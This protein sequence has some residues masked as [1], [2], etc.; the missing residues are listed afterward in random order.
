MRFRTTHPVL[1]LFC[2]SHAHTKDSE[3]FLSLPSSFMAL[4]TVYEQHR[5][6][7]MTYVAI[8]I[9]VSLI[10]CS[11]VS[12]STQNNQLFNSPIPAP[13]TTISLHAVRCG[14]AVRDDQIL[15]SPSIQYLSD[16]NVN[17]IEDD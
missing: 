11:T 12:N 2:S 15:R 7:A 8:T 10:I 6:I 17:K 4:D 14:V 13:T 9:I 3:L 16:S 1:V 5:T